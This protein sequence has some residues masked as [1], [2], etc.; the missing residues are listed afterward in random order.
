MLAGGKLKYT[1]IIFFKFSVSSL[2]L[3]E[4]EP[5]KVIDKQYNND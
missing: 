2:G 5:D 1:Y 4:I 3:N